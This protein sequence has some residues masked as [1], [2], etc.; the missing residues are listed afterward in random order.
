MA[1]GIGEQL[2]GMVRRARNYWSE[3]TDEHGRQKH[4]TGQERS[5]E[6]VH[7]RYGGVRTKS[8]SET[9]ALRGG[10]PGGSPGRG[11]AEAPWDNP[12]GRSDQ[13]GRQPGRGQPDRGQQMHS[14]SQT[15][16][17]YTQQGGSGFQK[18]LEKQRP[19]QA[20]TG[21]T[22][23]DPGAGRNRQGRRPGQQSH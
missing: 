4:R 3:L 19:G 8:G 2:K 5:D 18:S 10:R 6:E 17:Q 15:S 12:A 14:E 23:S 21:G 20:R 22:G 1:T 7:Q 11:N 9:D 13:Q 16:R